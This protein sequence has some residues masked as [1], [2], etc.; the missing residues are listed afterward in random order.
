VLI[1]P[2]WSRTN[3]ILN[4]FPR[5]I[6]LERASYLFFFLAALLL[7]GVADL[8]VAPYP[9][10]YET[11]TWYA[12]LMMRFQAMSVLEVLT[13]TFRVGT[14]F[15]MLMWFAT[16]VSSAHAFTLLKVSGAVLYG[17]LAMAVF[18][19]LRRGLRFE[20]KIAFVSSLLLVFQVAT[21][22]VSWDRFRTV[23]G[24]V[25]TFIAITVMKSDHR[26]KWPFLAGLAVLTTLSREYIALTLFV[27]VLG[28]AFLERKERSMSF[29]ALAPALSMFAAMVHST[30]LWENYVSYGQFA[31]GNYLLT[32]RD[33]LSIF[34]VCYL[35]LLPF[36]LKGF[37]RD[38]L[39]DPF[40][41][42]LLV[43]SFS[44]A[45][46]P[47]FAVPDYQRWLMLLVFP[48]S[49]YASLGFEGYNLFKR[50]NFRKLISILLIFM[51]IGVGYSTGGFSYVGLVPNS[52]VA[53]NLVQS[54]IPWNQID[55]VKDV[56]VWLDENAMFNSSVLAEE[57]FYGWTLIYL[58]RAYCDIEVVTYGATSMPWGALEKVLDDGSRWIYL[59][60]YNDLDLENFSIVYSRNDVSVFQYELSLANLTLNNQE[61]FLSSS[62]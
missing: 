12:P 4:Y 62:S 31:V 19:F 46:C 42:F 52:Y 29:V 24:L 55:D 1:L 22:R 44:V 2:I 59:I 7:R 45:L 11:I 53:V 26:F 13:E 37:R 20:W 25:F 50:A 32:V 39:L 51:A 47:W 5:V 9:V 33:T 21:L 48:F 36:V 3:S 8:L 15:Y 10:G 38:R 49:I 17:C 41:G 58:E 16:V 43:G 40:T 18:A 28:F 35:P 54:S 30:G 61:I 14:L 6:G 56:L 23:L 57:R 60:W 34:A 27:I